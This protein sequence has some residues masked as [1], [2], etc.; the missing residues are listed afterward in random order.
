MHGCYC[1]ANEQA[2]AMAVLY[3]NKLGQ[4]TYSK[5]STILGLAIPGIRQTQ[6]LKSKLVDEHYMPRSNDW[7]IEEV[8]IGV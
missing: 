4:K 1:K 2:C 3:S 7:A 8:S 6:K 5:P